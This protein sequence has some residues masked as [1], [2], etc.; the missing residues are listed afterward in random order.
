MV[1]TLNF[2]EP[3]NYQ[4][5]LE[6]QQSHADC[7]GIYIWGFKNNDNF[8]PYYVGKSESSVYL[9]VRSHF[10]KI[11]HRNTYTIFKLS[12]YSH[13]SANLDSLPRKAKP[14]KHLSNH[15]NLSPQLLY[16]NDT[17]FLIKL[18]GQLV[19]K[20]NHSKLKKGLFSQSLDKFCSGMP[21]QPTISSVFAPPNLFVTYACICNE[22]DTIQE[23]KRFIRNAE[24][25][26]K[27]CLVGN[28][29]GDSQSPTKIHP[30]LVISSYND[31]LR[32][33]FYPMLGTSPSVIDKK[34]HGYV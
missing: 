3:I 30:N 10:N 24:T 23:W 25:A 7:P 29:I 27:F 14:Y 4:T 19:S 26:V 5:F 28:T 31:I 16:L 18:F 15:L 21:I 33:Q 22:A 9:R 20:S 8:I 12:F 13:L 11:H 1:T 6:T 2:I 17:K 34:Y 32:Q